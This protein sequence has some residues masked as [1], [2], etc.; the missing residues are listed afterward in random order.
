MRRRYDPNP[1]F[2]TKASGIKHKRHT[3]AVITCIVIA[4]LSLIT[5]FVMWGAHMQSIYKEK[6]PDMVGAATAT[7]TKRTTEETSSES[8]SET[9]T[10]ETTEE[11]TT[12]AGLLPSIPTGTT[13]AAAEE[14]EATEQNNYPDPVPAYDPIIFASGHPVQSVSHEDRDMMLESLQQ[15]IISYN[16]ANPDARICFRYVNLASNET[17][18]VNDLS[19]IVPAGA[20]SLPTSIRYC[21]VTASGEVSPTTVI[22]F[23]GDPPEAWHYNSWIG[24]TYTA[25]KEF[26]LATCVDLSITRNDS[27]AMDYVESRIG[28]MDG[29]DETASG[30]SNYIDFYSEVTYTDYTGTVMRGGGRSCVYDLASFMEYAYYGYL[31]EP[32]TYLPLMGAMNESL[33][34]TPYRTAFGEEVT[35]LHVSG[36]NEETHSYTDVALIDGEEPIILAISVECSSQDRANVIIAD[37]AGYVQAFLASCHQ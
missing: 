14:T 16:N 4:A 7:H 15:S 30:I 26:Y 9:T 25:G 6:F 22:T 27:L 29:I 24:T 37:L 19:P 5:V 3:R 8:T 12:A 1:T 33:M 23:L 32:D 17:L 10:E 20:W 18:G 11:T 13:T 35:I 36:R 2:L 34:P 28:G 31:N 21:E